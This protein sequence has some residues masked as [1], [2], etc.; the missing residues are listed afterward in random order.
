MSILSVK[1]LTV[2]YGRLTAVREVSFSVRSGAIT[3]IIGGNGAGKTTIMKAVMGL[4][5]SAG[6][7]HFGAEPV[8]GKPVH[9]LV[10]MGLALVPEGRRLFP[11]M[12]VRENLMTG[13]YH[14]RDSAAV[15]ADLERVLDYFPALRPRMTSPA[16]NLSGGQQQ[17]VAVG[18]ALMS[19]PKLLLLDEPSIGLAPIIVQTIATILDDI[20][21]AGTDV[22][23][24]EQNSHMALRLSQYAYVLE[25]GRV[26]LEGEASDLLRSDYVQ[27]AYL[28]I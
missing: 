13:A 2:G 10:A 19:A 23:L 25:N 11:T 9:E 27:K 7:I 22:L 28:G 26:S 5:P 18:R 3:A 15:K 20:N 4:I 1:N 24:V 17:M 14:R 6:D 12:T 8:A 21:R 16:R